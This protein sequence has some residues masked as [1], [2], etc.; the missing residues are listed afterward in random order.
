MH[1]KEH[2]QKFK[3]KRMERITKKKSMPNSLPK[4]FRDNIKTKEDWPPAYQRVSTVVSF[5]DKLK[6]DP[7][8]REHPPKP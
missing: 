8:K 6:H 4:K 2:A 7:R 3:D 5:T 1:N